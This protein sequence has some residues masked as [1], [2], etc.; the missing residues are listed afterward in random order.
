MHGRGGIELETNNHSVHTMINDK[1]QNVLK[2]DSGIF[3]TS[4]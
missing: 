3:I 4:K 2:T 1:K